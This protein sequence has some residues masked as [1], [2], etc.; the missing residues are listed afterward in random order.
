MK[1][2]YLET[3]LFNVHD[4]M[5]ALH[6]C[7]KVD[8]W[9]DAGEL[10]G[11]EHCFL[12]YRDSNNQIPADVEHFGK[13]IFEH[14]VKN[15]KSCC[16]VIGYFD[17][18]VYDSGCGFEIGFAYTMGYPI[19]LITTDSFMCSAGNSAEVYP[20]S[21]LLQH[22]A[23]VVHISEPDPSIADFGAACEELLERALS[24]FRKNLAADFGSGASLKETLKAE[25]LVFDYYLDPNFQYSES[26]RFLLS[27][28]TKAIEK[29]GKTYVIGNNRDDIEATITDLKKSGKAILFFDQVDP[30]VD[31]AILDGIAYGLGKQP[32]IYSSME[33]YFLNNGV[34]NRIN[35]R[36]EFSSSAIVRTLEELI[37]IL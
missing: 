29:S 13:A 25:E 19:H 16:G 10:P 15:L 3:K 36:N 31:S 9:I 12:P 32:I 37:S 14:D 4:R 20:V 24:E 11:M 8:S 34:K 7:E 21:R 26:G 2:F 5:A 30:N 1:R 23:N 33:Q 17:G 22:V 6:L 28:I 27:N 35:I 18:P